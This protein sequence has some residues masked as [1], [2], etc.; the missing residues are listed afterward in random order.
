[1]WFDLISWSRWITPT[2]EKKRFDTL[3][4]IHL[5]PNDHQSEISVDGHEVVGYGWMSPKEA[6]LAFERKGNPIGVHGDRN[7]VISTPVLHAH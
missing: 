2:H 6:L 5:L 1:M 4:F 3:F 7:R